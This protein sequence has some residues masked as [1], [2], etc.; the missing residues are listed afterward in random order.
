ML[1]TSRSQISGLLE[2]LTGLD[3]A[4][5]GSAVLEQLIAERRAELA[6][7]NDDAYAQ[8]LLTHAS[9]QREIAQRLLVTESWFE[10]DAG[11]L[12]A[13]AL[14]IPPRGART[15]GKFRVLC[16]PCAQGE[17]AFSVAARLIAAGYGPD[18]AQVIAVD[19]SLAA[20]DR[21]QQSEHPPNAWRSDASQAPWWLSQSTNGWVVH[22]SVRAMVQ[23]SRVNLIDP[24]ASAER[25]G[26]TQHFDAIFSRNF[27]IYLTSTARKAWLGQ[28]ASLLKPNGLVFTGPSEAIHQWSEDFSAPGIGSHA[29]VYSLGKASPAK[30][31]SFRFDPPKVTRVKPLQTPK[32]ERVLPPAAAGRIEHGPAT[33]AEQVPSASQ[34]RELADAGNLRAAHAALDLRM[35][36]KPEADDYVLRALLCSAESRKEEA[37]EALERALYCARPPVG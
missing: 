21:A 2:Q 6:L 26:T 34:V 9:E 1:E 35:K 32:T 33:A 37:E 16:A 13:F 10:R 3:D 5:L 30:K 12:G 20:L 27:L 24:V 31:P 22:D 7:K 23:F 8:Y 28:I 4:S 25:L 15:D 14:S 11:Q 17:E 19:Y 36:S 29:Y 18:S